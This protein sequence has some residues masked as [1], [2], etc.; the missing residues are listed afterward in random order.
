M[1]EAESKLTER[2]KAIDA[3]SKSVQKLIVVNDG[4]K[5]YNTGYE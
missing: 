1:A 5:H 4:D 3:I 2:E